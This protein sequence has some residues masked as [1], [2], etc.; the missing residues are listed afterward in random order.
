MSR[1]RSVPLWPAALLLALPLAL[2]ACGK[3]PGFPDAPPNAE[4]GRF[5]PDPALDPQPAGQAS[6][7]VPGTPAPAAG[8]PGATPGTG[9]VATPGAEDALKP[10]DPIARRP[11]SRSGPA[12]PPSGGGM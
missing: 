8:Q 2:T 5:Y 3:K 11:G 6:R 9:T 12:I 4:P 7:P 1:T 10:V